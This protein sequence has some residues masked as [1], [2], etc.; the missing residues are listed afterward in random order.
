MDQKILIIGDSP[1]ALD[2]YREIFS[3]PQEQHELL[4]EVDSLYELL[5]YS[6]KP[7]KGVIGMVSFSNHY[8]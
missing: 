5:G 4:D 2:L 1:D 7:T 8:I 3:Y 6:R